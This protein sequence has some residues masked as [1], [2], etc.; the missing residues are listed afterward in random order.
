MDLERRTFRYPLSFLI[1][2][3]AFDGLPAL[4][5]DPVYRRLRTVLEA[6]DGG[7]AYA[8]LDADDRRAILEILLETKPDF[9]G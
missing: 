1:Y 2:S 7:E 3:E 8:H 5:K 6:G 4:V 9:G